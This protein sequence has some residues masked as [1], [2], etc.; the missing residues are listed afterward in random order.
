MSILSGGIMRKVTQNLTI[1]FLLCF[2]QPIYAQDYF[3]EVTG[4]SSDECYREIE[5]CRVS[6]LF[7]A[8]F[9]DREEN[10][11]NTIESQEKQLEDINK[12]IN[13]ISKSLNA[14]LDNTIN[15][16]SA[17]DKRVR[18][19]KRRLKRLHRL[20]NKL[21]TNSNRVNSS[22][23]RI[24]KKIKRK[25]IKLNNYLESK[26]ASFETEN[27]S[28]LQSQIAQLKLSFSNITVQKDENTEY[29]AELNNERTEKYQ[30]VD[31][32]CRANLARCIPAIGD[33]CITSNSSDL[34]SNI[35]YPEYYEP[36]YVGT[37][38]SVMFR[39]LK[40][41]TTGDDLSRE[42]VI[43][44]DG[45]LCNYTC[46]SRFPEQCLVDGSYDTYYIEQCYDNNGELIDVTQPPS[47]REDYD[48]NN[49][50]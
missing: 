20:Y 46:R 18:K 12:S 40:D 17:S 5:S 47:G 39:T 19:L 28:P 4:T 49:E 2:Y 38:A 23:K 44:L 36:G 13:L 6:R 3:P 10:L 33:Q 50:D 7:L 15:I 32:F 14:A 11:I 48:S 34:P 43:V 45:T 26:K 29:L 1:L 22:A 24:L 16:V 8:D 9:Q 25:Q 42:E 35:L 41:C 21:T 31:A 37:T 30:F 27:I